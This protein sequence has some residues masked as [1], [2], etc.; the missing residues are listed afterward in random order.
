M[1][2]LEIQC[3]G[4]FHGS[5]LLLH[6]LSFTSQSADEDFW[7]AEKRRGEMGNLW[8]GAAGRGKEQ[9]MGHTG[10]DELEKKMDG[11]A[12]VLCNYFRY[13]SWWMRS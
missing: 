7:G 4:V 9:V 10:G 8:L 6:G 3:Q 12:N 5:M 11:Y 2:L 1:F 13:N